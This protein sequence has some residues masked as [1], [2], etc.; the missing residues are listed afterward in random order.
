MGR[1]I[2][3]GLN[4]TFLDP[5][6]SQ[7]VGLVISFSAQLCR[8]PTSGQPPRS[9]EPSLRPFHSKN[10]RSLSPGSP[11]EPCVC[12][13]RPMAYRANNHE[14]VSFFPWNTIAHVGASIKDI[15]VASLDG[16]M[17]AYYGES[18]RA[19]CTRNAPP[20]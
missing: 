15:N 14:M 7:K 9:H 3:F 5:L 10:F 8:G 12:A 4:T 11:A 17:D 20:A 18:W 1:W 13:K 16:T 19:L 6:G 2:T